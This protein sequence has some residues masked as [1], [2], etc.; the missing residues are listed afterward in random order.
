[1]DLTQVRERLTA[2]DRQLIEL[3]AERKRL[4]GGV[5][6]AKRSTGQATRD[7]RREPAD[8]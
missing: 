3:V 1:M 8:G 2:L 7:Y 6:R 4:S 5:A